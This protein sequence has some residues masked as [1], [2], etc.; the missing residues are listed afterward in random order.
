MILQ[1]HLYKTI[2]VTQTEDNQLIA[3][4]A[5]NLE[6]IIFKAHFPELPVV[7][8]AC[9]VQISKE[10]ISNTINQKINITSFKNLKFLKTINPVEFPNLICTFSIQEKEAEILACITYS[11]NNFVFCKLDYFFTK[12]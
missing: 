2:S 6:N 5:L 4:I 9:L 8:G 1:N 3:A 7:P 12:C 11:C 10:L